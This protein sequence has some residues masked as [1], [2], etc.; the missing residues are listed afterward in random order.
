MLMEHM[1]VPQFL[2]LLAIILGTVQLFGFLARK[3]G[4]LAVLGELVAEM[5]LDTS[6]L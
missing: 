3:M 2:G 4:Q 6:M 1:D 5:L